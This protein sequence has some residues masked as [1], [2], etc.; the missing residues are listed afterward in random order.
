[1]KKS[2]GVNAQSLVICCWH[3]MKEISFL[4][5]DIVGK[6]PLIIE[7][8]SVGLITTEQVAIDP[9]VYIN[10]QYLGRFYSCV[11]YKGFE[12]WKIIHSPLDGGKT[13]GSI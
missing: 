8:G 13:Y 4:L 7:T 10:P 2:S 12:Y 3:C 9:Y 5:G 6:T 1:M 11:A